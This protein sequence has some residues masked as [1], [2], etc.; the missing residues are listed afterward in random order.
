[1]TDVT[2]R[3]ITDGACRGNPGPGAW[4]A[5]LRQGEAERVLWGYAPQ[6]TNNRMEL[7]AALHGLE[8][9]KRPSSILIR[10][11]SQYLIKGMT[12]WLAGWQKRGWRSAGG[13]AVKN[14][15][16]WQGLARLAQ[17]HQL[18]WEWVRGH[19][20]DPEN[21]AVDALINRVLDHFAGNAQEQCGEGWL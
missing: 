8:A 16:L 18:R 2:L 5:W 4:G 20:G 14:V 9:L 13:S 19:S 21:E 15:E 12:E 3:L 10:S 7:G 17:T 11:D 6:T 1:M